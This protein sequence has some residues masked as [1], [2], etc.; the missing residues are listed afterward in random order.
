MSHT[1]YN[2]TLNKIP[3]QPEITMNPVL[4]VPLE[5]KAPPAEPS[6]RN[7]TGQSLLI[8]TW[9]CV[10]AGAD[11]ICTT[12]VDP[13]ADAPIPE[14]VTGEWIV[15]AADSRRRIGK[16]RSRPCA[17]GARAW[18]EY[19]HPHRTHDIAYIAKTATHGPYYVAWQ[20]PGV[21]AGAARKD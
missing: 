2:H 20:C 7:S 5:A 13:G 21:G 12:L 1:P 8:E 14:S 9:V 19:D 11:R 18:A 16:F 4:S 3:V 15:Y 6:F 17:S 10:C